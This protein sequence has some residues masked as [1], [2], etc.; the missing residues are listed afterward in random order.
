MN[1]RDAVD[2]VRQAGVWFDPAPDGF[3]PLLGLVGVGDADLP[4]TFRLALSQRGLRPSS[5]ENARHKLATLHSYTR[6]RVL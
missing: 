6:L 2:L 5:C 1:D 3:G 4:E